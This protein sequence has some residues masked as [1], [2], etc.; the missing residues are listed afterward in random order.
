[1]EIKKIEITDELI[2]KM[3]KKALSLQMMAFE[4]FKLKEIK[5]ADEYMELFKQSKKLNTE[6]K[7][8]QKLSNIE[9]NLYQ[10]VVGRFELV[11]RAVS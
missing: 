3:N 1:M 4:F 8:L 6:L 7:L 9:W 10:D 5:K 11:Q 2:E